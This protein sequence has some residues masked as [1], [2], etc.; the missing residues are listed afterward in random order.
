MIPAV[1]VALAPFDNLSGDPA[2]DYLAHGFAEDLAAELSRFATLQVLYPRAV[3]AFLR[4]TASAAENP[5]TF[6]AHI[7]RGSIR[8]VRDV[9][10]VAVQL[11]EL[12]SGRQVWASRYDATATEVLAVQ[13]EIAARVAG[14]LALHVDSAR[15]AASRRTPLASLE[16]YDCWLRGLDCLQRGTNEADVEARALFEQALAIDPVFARGYAGLSLSHFNEWS[17]QAWEHWDDKERLSYEYAMRAADLDGSDAVVQIVLG[18][19]LLYRRQFDAAAHHVERALALNPNEANVLAHALFCLGLLGDPGLAADLATRARRL[20]PHFPAWYAA[21]EAQA[22]FLLGRYEEATDTA[23][24]TPSG[25]VDLPAWVAASCALAGD[26]TRARIHA[27]RFLSDFTTRITFGRT[28]DPGEPLR[29][30][31]HVNPFRHAADGERLAPGLQLAGLERDPDDGRPEATVHPAGSDNVGARFC[32]EGAFWSITFDGLA[33]QLTDQKGF[34]DLARLLTRP[35]QEVH[36]LELANRPQAG[37]GSDRVL[38]ERARRD[39]QARV[40]DL[41][42]ELDDAERLND[43][44]RS[45]RSREELDQIAE[46]LSGA[47][48]LGGRPRRLGSGAERARSAVTWR[49]RSAIKKISTTH[50]RLGRH[51]ENSLRTGTFCMYQP[52]TP[53][54]WAD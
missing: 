44:S 20:N 46:F 52:E 15:L 43:T 29:W 12:P 23:L 7:L 32:R 54:E 33:V 1:T 2:E 36:C 53:I 35:G 4:G 30:L 8:R 24:K 25:I 27:R 11:F 17:C 40:R 6:A 9:I 10:R 21:A 14:A 31:L 39:I 37:D 3:E 38:D 51:L 18:R 48:G 28:P 19:T 13:D 47:L 49:I 16:V 26:T 45:E 42:R 41:Q 22:L 50:P 5:A 34:H